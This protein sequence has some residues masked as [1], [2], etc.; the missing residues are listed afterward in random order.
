M[1][2]LISKEDMEE[3]ENELGKNMLEGV[4]MSPLVLKEIEETI[5]HVDYKNREIEL[6]KR[7]SKGRSEGIEEGIKEGIKEGMKKGRSEALEVVVGRMWGVFSVE[8]I[9]MVT[10]LSVEDIKKMV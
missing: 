5:K 2:N 7:E 6:E 1:K 10:G 9:S 4:S 8:D 3:I